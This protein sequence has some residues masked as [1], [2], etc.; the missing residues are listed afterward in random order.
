M[1]ETFSEVI[2]EPIPDDKN[3][4][5]ILDRNT[6]LIQNNEVYKSSTLEYK[7]LENVNDNHLTSIVKNLEPNSNIKLTKD[8]L[9][10]EIYTSLLIYKEHQDKMET[11][12][13]HPYKLGK[14]KT[15]FI[16]FEN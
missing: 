6:V 14:F 12:C 5:L 3:R 13:K 7:N 1:N 10:S 9:E 4:S 8:S 15:F 16:K 11:N 2:F